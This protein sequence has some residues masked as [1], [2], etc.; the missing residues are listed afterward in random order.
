MLFLLA[1]QADS[2]SFLYVICAIVAFAERAVQRAPIVRNCHPPGVRDLV[3][4]TTEHPVGTATRQIGARPGRGRGCI[5]L[6]G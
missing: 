4:R 2:E 3:Q 1:I 5:R 6:A